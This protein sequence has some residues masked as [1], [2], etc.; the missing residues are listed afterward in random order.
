MEMLSQV[1]NLTSSS[2]LLSLTIYSLFKNALSV[3]KKTGLWTTI[4]SIDNVKID[5]L[6]IRK[7]AELKLSRQS[8][9]YSES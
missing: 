4:F 9:S 5:S 6:L 2:L 3:K 8:C 1:V 7:P